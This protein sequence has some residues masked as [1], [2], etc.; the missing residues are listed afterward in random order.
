MF[1]KKV[2]IIVKLCIF[3]TRGLLQINQSEMVSLQNSKIS[4][5][6]ITTGW[7]NCLGR[8]LPCAAA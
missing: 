2:H 8:L 1:V 4:N 6:C 5:C 3:L 7:R